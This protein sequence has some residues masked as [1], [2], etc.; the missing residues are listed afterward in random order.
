[1]SSISEFEKKDA[2]IKY[3][4]VV[5]N[6]PKLYGYMRNI[7]SFFPTARS[8]PYKLKDTH[9]NILTLLDTRRP[10]DATDNRSPEIFID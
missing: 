1:M 6:A 3:N 8:R 4:D 5:A 10:S 9:T 2:C 7:S